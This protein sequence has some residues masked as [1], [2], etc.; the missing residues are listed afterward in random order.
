MKKARDEKA[1]DIHVIAG[2][3]P[4]FRIHGEI[5]LADAPPLTP[6]QTTQMTLSMLTESQRAELEKE[7]ELSVSVTDAQFGRFRVTVYCHAGHPEMAL[8]MCST[9]IP[10]REELGLPDIV[11]ELA[12]SASG[13]ILVTG[14]TGM[15]K[16]TTLNYM[17]DVINSERRCKVVTIEDPI[18][19]LHRSKKALVVQEEVGTDVHSFSRALVHVLR[20]DPDVICVG[21]MRNLETIS[22][23]LTAAETGHLVI[24]TLHTPN[25][26][27]TVERIVDVFPAGQQNQVITQLANS[28]Q[29]VIAQLLLTRAD[30]R[31]RVLA[32]EVLIATNAVRT[33]IRENDLPKL[34]S[35]IQTGRK[36]GMHTM[37]DSL[38][39]LY[40][41]AQ[42]TYDAALSHARDP[43]MIT[44]DYKPP[45]QQ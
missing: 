20:Q 41:G 39:R 14:A 10:S 37:D 13:L 1:S 43:K 40:E 9:E 22:T 45:A 23:A 4:A 35:V 26:L 31:G 42:I 36:W 2:L 15:G 34:Q 3:P 12:R 6:E 24:A 27:Q 29:A 32:T 8:R 28:L 19:F 17:L 16:T 11:D 7:W 38:R 33:V 30:K 44:G 5:I 21:E 18:E 25:A